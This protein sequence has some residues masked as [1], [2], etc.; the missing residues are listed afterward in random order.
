MF[1]AI[2]NKSKSVEKITAETA[3]AEASSPA[4]SQTAEPHN[5]SII[6][7]NSAARVVKVMFSEIKY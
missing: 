6:R 1:S 4:V 2:E 5:D 7:Q 3:V